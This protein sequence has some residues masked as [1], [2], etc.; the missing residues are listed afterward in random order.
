MVCAPLP[1]PAKP[2]RRR[3]PRAEHG[4]DLRR[5]CLRSPE[6]SQMARIRGPRRQRR[7]IPELDRCVDRPRY[8][9]PH[10]PLV[11][12]RLAPIRAYPDGR[13]LVSVWTPAAES[14]FAKDRFPLVFPQEGPPHCVRMVPEAVTSDFPS[15]HALESARQAHRERTARTFGLVHRARRTLSRSTRQPQPADPTQDRRKQPPGHRDF[16]ELEDHVL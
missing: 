4:A 9:H 5:A 12:A 16:C 7:R 14:T 13:T 6:L 2:T 3:A 10:P 8:G 11:P 1:C 15:T